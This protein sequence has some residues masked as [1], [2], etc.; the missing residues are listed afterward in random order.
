M[1]CL[2]FRSAGPRPAVV[3][4]SDRRKGVVSVGGCVWKI[5]HKASHLPGRLPV[6]VSVWVESRAALRRLLRWS[7]RMRQTKTNM[8]PPRTAPINVAEGPCVAWGA[9]GIVE[10]VCVTAGEAIRVVVIEGSN[11]PGYDTTDEVESWDNVVV[12]EGTV[13]LLEGCATVDLVDSE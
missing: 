8:I 7:I 1:S 3:S 9:E 2:W 11:D 4:A 5:R 13:A 6:C 10:G 12:A